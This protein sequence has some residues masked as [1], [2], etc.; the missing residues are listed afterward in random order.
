[1]TNNLAFYHICLDDSYSWVSIVTDQFQEMI[2]T[3]VYK[4]LS[5]LNITVIGKANHTQEFIGLVSYFNNIMGVP[6]NIDLLDKPYSDDDF[7]YIDDPSKKHLFITEDYTLQ[8]IW[9]RSQKEE[10]NAL[11]FHAKGVT[12]LNRIFKKGNYA[13][14]VNY[15]FWR[16]HLEWGVMESH[17][18]ALDTLKTYDVVGTNFSIWPTPHYSGNFW[19][20]KSNYIKDLAAPKDKDW[21]DK[22]RQYNPELNNISYR[23]SAEM[24]IGSGGAAKLYSLYTHHSPPPISNLADTLLLKRDYYK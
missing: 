9:E 17:Q 10:F 2:D 8:K 6:F 19:W 22:Y 3:G 14:Y 18:L 11:Y 20:A 24:W 4:V 13:R 5:E 12:S 7:E 15:H 16:K 23:T 1:M 21:W